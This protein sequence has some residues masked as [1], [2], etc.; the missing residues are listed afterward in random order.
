[1]VLKMGILL[2]ILSNMSNN[3]FPIKDN[4][5]KPIMV[6]NTKDVRIST[7]GISYGK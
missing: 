3:F 4:D 6:I 7:P 1:M 2:K 5:K